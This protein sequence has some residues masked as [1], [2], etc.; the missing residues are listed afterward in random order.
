MKT[1]LCVIFNHP[2]REQIPLLRELYGERFETILFLHPFDPAAAADDVHVVYGG[3]FTFDA[4]IASARDRILRRFAGCDLV[5]FLHN[6]CLLNPS[7][8]SDTFASE[9][10]IEPGTILAPGFGFVA[11]ALET[12]PWA[13]RAAANWLNPKSL[14]AGGGEHVKAFLPTKADA[15]AA[16]RKHG[17]NDATSLLP[18]SDSALALL[19]AIYRQIHQ[20]IFAA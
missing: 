12:W 4:M 17:L 20:D 7:I 18:A 15:L 10:G 3:G 8:H 11:G 16:A 6:D 13:F 5:V 1:G 19:P 14:F 2:F 9:F